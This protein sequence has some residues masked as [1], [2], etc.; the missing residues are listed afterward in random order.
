M[1]WIMLDEPTIGQDR[2]TRKVLAAIMSPLRHR[3]RRVMVTHD[4]DFAACF[5]HR[6]LRIEEWTIKTE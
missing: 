5:P 2:A 6:R 4:D 1:P 3:L